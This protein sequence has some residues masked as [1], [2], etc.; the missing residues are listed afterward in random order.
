MT[1]NDST[2]FR[3]QDAPGY[4]PGM[5]ATIAMQCFLFVGTL[6]MAFIYWRRNKAADRDGLP[7]QGVIGW[8]YTL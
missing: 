2:I 4:K 8:R 3:A 7:V 5:Y 1:T 6:F